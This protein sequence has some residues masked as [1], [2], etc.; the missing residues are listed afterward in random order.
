MA[1]LGE[2]I[3]RYHKLLGQPRYRDLT[4]AEELQEQ[5]R[6]RHL[7]DSGLVLPVLRPHF[8]SKRQLETL[9]RVSEHLAAIL[10]QIEGLALESPP[11]LNRL[12]MLPAEKMLA[13]IPSTYS[14]FSITSR[15]EAHLQNGSLCLGG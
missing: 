1:Q 12:Q 13:A 6:T 11:L 7:M 5:I 8:V 2:A 14:R 15:M 3:A 10:D 4:W 9:T